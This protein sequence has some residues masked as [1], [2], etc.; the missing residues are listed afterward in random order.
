MLWNS[1]FAFNQWCG[2]STHFCH[3][4][5]KIKKEEIKLKDDNK[6]QKVGNASETAELV[7][8]ASLLVTYQQ[9]RQMLFGVPRPWMWYILHTLGK[10]KL[11]CVWWFDFIFVQTLCCASQDSN[12]E[13]YLNLFPIDGSAGLL[14]GCSI[15]CNFASNWVLEQNIWMPK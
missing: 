2:S 7:I 9:E 14:V 1:Y 6:T 4:K 11:W 3:T 12:E 5:K 15:S 13:G 10:E 8:V